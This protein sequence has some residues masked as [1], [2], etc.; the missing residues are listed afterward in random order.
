LLKTKVGS[1]TLSSTC[2]IAAR[3]FGNGENIDLGCGPQENAVEKLIGIEDMAVERFERVVSLLE[4]GAVDR[5][6]RRRRTG[7]ESGD[8]PENGPAGE[9]LRPATQPTAA[10]IT[11]GLG[12]IGS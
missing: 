1:F 2:R 12:P 8:Q 10:K 11:E 4:S 3:I 5:V 7:R 9:R 6:G